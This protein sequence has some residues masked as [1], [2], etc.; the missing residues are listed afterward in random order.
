[1][2][3][4]E[5][6]KDRDGILTREDF[7]RVIK[8]LLG[9]SFDAEVMSYIMPRYAEF[10][11]DRINILAFMHDIYYLFLS[12]KNRTGEFFDFP[13]YEPSPQNTVMTRFATIM[14][15]KKVSAEVMAGELIDHCKSNRIRTSTIMLKVI[16]ILEDEL[17]G[18]GNKGSAPGQKEKAPLARIFEV[19]DNIDKDRRGNIMD[20]DLVSFLNSFLRY[21]MR[22]VIESIVKKIANNHTDLSTYFGEAQDSHDIVN[23]GKLLSFL[24]NK[25]NYNQNG[26]QQL[27]EKLGLDK[28]RSLHISKV[29]VGFEHQL[30][31]LKIVED[32]SQIKSYVYG[33]AA[34]QLNA[35]ELGVAGIIDEMQK[36]MSLMQRSFDSV[37]GGSNLHSM[38][39]FDFLRGLGIVD[40]ATHPEKPRLMEIIK[41]KRDDK[42]VNMYTFRQIFNSRIL[43][44]DGET[45]KAS[46]V[47]LEQTI[48][49]LRET[50]KNLGPNL[51]ALFSKA[52][53]NG[54][55]TLDKRVTLNYP[56]NC[57][58][59]CSCS[60]IQ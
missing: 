8:S 38:P 30:V 57:F 54:T 36:R 17:F 58:S 24:V 21:E 20:Y 47:S 19:I 9:S 15:N 28:G 14:Q 13:I 6:D 26:A 39:Q 25:E 11:D 16:N 60:M 51:A 43:S 40:L 1:M 52:D 50:I 41:D 7:D 27:I 23:G 44:K 45:S 31:L 33:Q 22:F 48:K 53:S 42:L 10:R 59:C 49:N 3:L 5:K 2:K 56:R 18:M 35:E 34:A 12:Q 32:L 4:M 55:N 29:Q 46:T 37:F